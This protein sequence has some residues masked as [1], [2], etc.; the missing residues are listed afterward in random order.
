LRRMNTESKDDPRFT[1][2]VGFALKIELNNPKF[3][4]ILTPYLHAN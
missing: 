4:R 3:R 2:F 1:L